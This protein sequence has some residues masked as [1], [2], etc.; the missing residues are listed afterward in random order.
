MW[1]EARLSATKTKA[2]LK[3]KTPYIARH[4][5]ANPE[6]KQ[7]AA[8][9]ESLWRHRQMITKVREEDFQQEL[10]SFAE[11][12][13]SEQADALEADEERVQPALVRTSRA[14]AVAPDRY[15]LVQ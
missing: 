15:R 12:L 1:A 4:D 3:I 5:H 10:T 9:E 11:T 6:A 13:T 2:S 7:A 8:L 14:P